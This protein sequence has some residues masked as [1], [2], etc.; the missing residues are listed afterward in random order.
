[1]KRFLSKIIVGLMAFW[2]CIAP[3]IGVYAATEDS[4]ITEKSDSRVAVGSPITW[5]SGTF[6]MNTTTTNSKKHFD[7]GSITIGFSS[8][9][10]EYSGKY[11]VTLRKANILGYTDYATFSILSNGDSTCTWTNMPAGDYV[12]SFTPGDSTSYQSYKIMGAYSH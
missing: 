10:S 11:K 4:V 12:L 2:L 3:S 6:V 5:S 9:N 8:S 1:M 7:A